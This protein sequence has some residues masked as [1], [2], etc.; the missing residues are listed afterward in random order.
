MTL[1]APPEAVQF[2][3]WFL[4]EFVRQ[5][6]GEP[7]SPWPLER[8]QSGVPTVTLAA[9]EAMVVFTGELDLS[10]AGDLLQLIQGRRSEG[11]ASL[12]LD[13]S[14]VTFIDSVGLSL[15]VSTFNRVTE[16]GGRLVVIL[17]HR[18]RTLFEVTGLLDVLDP[19]FVT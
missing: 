16:E 15:L 18:L 9:G 14:G 13:L 12:T 8:V 7:P 19:E 1:A 17:P 2:R 3:E 4:G 10:S 5:A 11:A 6:R